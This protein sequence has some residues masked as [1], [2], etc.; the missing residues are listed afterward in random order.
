MPLQKLQFTPGV[1]RETTTYQNEGGYYACDKIRF[2]SGQPE[3]VGGWKNQSTGTQTISG[4]TVVFNGLFKGT[5]RS[6]FNWITFTND[7]LLGV[8]TNQKFYVELYGNYYDITPIAETLTLP[9]NPFATTLDSYAVVVTTSVT[10][11]ISIGTYVTFAGVSGSGVVNG[12]TLN[13][14]FE[15]IATPSATS[16][17]IRANQKALSTG[18]GGGAAVT[19]AVELNAG[20][21]VFSLGL[22]WGGGPWGFGGWGIGSTVSTQIRLWSQDNDQ[23]NLL[24]NPRSGPIFY[25]TKDTAT[26]ARAITLNAKANTQVKAT[27]QADFASAVTTI[28]VIDPNGIDTGAVVSGTGIPA[29]TYVTTAYIAGSYTVPIS[30]ATTAPSSG[31]YTFSYSGRHVPNN[32]YQVSTS[33]VGNFCIAF[34]S[35][36][37]SPINFTEN[38][39]PLLVR[40]SDADNPFEWVPATTNQAGENRLSYGSY[41]VNAVDTRQEILIWTDAAIFSMQ[42][43]GPPYVWGINLLMENISIASPNAA[44]TVNNVTYWMGVDKFYA[45][46]G[47]VETLPCTLRQFIFTN[48]NTDQLAQIVCGTNEGYNEIW[49]FY[50]TADS[51]I[52]NRY[53]IYNHVERTWAYGTIERGFWL[54]SPLRQYPMAAFSHQSSFLSSTIDSTVV[55]LPMLNAA[56]YPTAGVVTIDLEKIYYTGKTSTSLTG[57]TRGYDGTAAASHGSYSAVTYYIPNQVMNH[58][59]DNDDQSLPTARPIEAYIESSDFD[60]GDGHNFGYVWRIL[61]DMNFNGS[62]SNTPA[63]TLTVKARQNSGTPYTQGD[64]PTVQE[65]AAIPIELYTGQVYTR[66]RGRQMA[67]RVASSDLGVAWQMGAM[68]IDIRP[69][70]RR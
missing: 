19:A 59:F 4:S 55:T 63:V 50:P 65:S 69:D 62:T 70:G 13:G 20:N 2:R 51:L 12:V 30:A 14:N 66:I 36:P 56:S 21:A 44:I 27:T 26:W 8:G 1:N 68:R 41:I 53:V 10:H 37:Y 52:N 49:W 24:F 33:S 40:W 46:S 57:C 48:I 3:K 29:G 6:L 58:E 15:V 25:W 18:S 31:D 60:I 54:D 47:R 28:T 67:F 61:P 16:I 43:L 32:T 7:N 11:N 23:E 39:D 38:F 34:G 17:T 45:Y 9:N 35:N 5:C 22:G 64:S 42:Y